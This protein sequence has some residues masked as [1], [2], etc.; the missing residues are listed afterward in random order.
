MKDIREWL[1]NNFYSGVDIFPKF[2][3]SIGIILFLLVVHTVI[4]MVLSRKIENVRSRYIWQK[5]VTY[6]LTFMGVLFLGQLWFR[7]IQDLTTF[8][9]LLSAGIAIAL[10]DVI[11]NLAGWVFILWVRPFTV[12][13]RIQIGNFSGDVIDISLFHITL[14]EIGNWV[15]ADQSTGRVIKIPNELV[16]TQSLANYSKGVQYIWNE[17]PV[18]ITFE[19]NWKKS[20]EI[21]LSIANKHAEHLSKKAEKKVREASKHFFI[22]YSKLTPVVYTSVKNSGVLLTIRYLSEPRR[23]RGTEQAIWE[24]VL[25]SFAECDDIDFAYPTQRFY[26]NIQ[27]GKQIAKLPTD[28]GNSK[29]E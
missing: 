2:L 24:D 7:G 1:H 13:D 20:K 10:K 12:S 9:G 15:E 26:S 25:M 21:F 17:I 18:L 11:T 23:R 6:F 5:T 4:I 28:V 19:S 22:Y 14:M 8:I 3:F 29:K 16:F 27:E